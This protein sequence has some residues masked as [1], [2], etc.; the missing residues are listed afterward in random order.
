MRRTP[1]VAQG[2]VHHRD[3]QKLSVGPTAH[4][5]DRDAL[6]HSFAVC[7]LRDITDDSEGPQSAMGSQI[8]LHAIERLDIAPA[9]SHLGTGPGKRESKSEGSTDAATAAGNQHGAAYERR[10]RRH[11]LRRHGNRSD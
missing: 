9:D 3:W 6:D 11:G 7:A 4:H 5:G 8:D 2:L 10:V 1:T